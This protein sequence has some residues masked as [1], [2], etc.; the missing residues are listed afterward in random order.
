[1]RRLKSF[2]PSVCCSTHLR[3]PLQVNTVQHFHCSFALL[4]ASR[5]HF[6]FS[7]LNNNKC[8]NM[9][10]VL[11]WLLFISIYQDPSLLFREKRC[12]LQEFKVTR[13]EFLIG[14]WSF[15]GWSI[16]LT[17]EKVYLSLFCYFLV[18]RVTK[19]HL[20]KLPP[21]FPQCLRRIRIMSLGVIKTVHQTRLLRNSV[22]T[23]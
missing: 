2:S 13:C 3:V 8:V 9:V 10:L 12:F 22:P 5:L 16:T 6:V 20:F 19:W 7:T 23:I 1:M 17:S 18:R 21:L 14:S 15:C 11:T 4:A